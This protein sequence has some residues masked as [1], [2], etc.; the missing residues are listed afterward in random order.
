MESKEQ[1]VIGTTDSFTYNGFK[2]GSFVIDTVTIPVVPWVGIPFD[3]NSVLQLSATSGA[4]TELNSL[5]VTLNTCTPAQLNGVN[6]I[7]SNSGGTGLQIPFTAAASIGTG[8]FTFEGWFY[9]TSTAYQYICDFGVNQMVLVFTPSSNVIS[10]YDS[11]YIISGAFGT[12]PVNQWMHL[13]VVRSNGLITLY[14]NGNSIA[15]GNHNTAFGST[16]FTFFGYGGG[17]YNFYGYA[18]DVRISNIARYS[19]T[20]MPTL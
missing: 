3:G 9:T 1:S 4:I 20:F 6:T 16:T 10:L 5:P 14:L 7:Y 17:G 12:I 11:G 2:P 19:T 18:K 15:S 13:A 8:D